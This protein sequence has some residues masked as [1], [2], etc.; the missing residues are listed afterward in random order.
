MKTAT[1]KKTPAAKNSSVK[2]KILEKFASV[3]K[4]LS[5]MRE[6][7]L[8]TVAR[9]SPPDSS[10]MGD[11][12]DQASLSIEK[13][14]LFELSDNERTTLDQIEAA[15]RKVE[16]G[17][18]GLCESCHNPIPKPRLKALPFARN[19]I[20]CQSASEHASNEEPADDIADIVIPGEEKESDLA[21]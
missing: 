9:K 10:E 13:E 8:K 18:Y 11:S 19:C 2:P 20:T 16:K 21:S 4:E 5:A 15:I 12:M 3:Y 14:L 6:D 7:V 17:I 1:K